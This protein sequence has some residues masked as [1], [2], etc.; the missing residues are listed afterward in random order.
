VE[1]W[2]LDG[3]LTGAWEA[4]RRPG[5]GDEGCG[6]RNSG[7]EHAQA[8]RVGNGAGDECGEEGRALCCFIGSEGKRNRAA[9]GGGINVGR[10]VWWGGETE[11]W[12]GSEEGGKCGAIF[13]RGGVIGAAAAR[14]GGA[15]GGRSGFRRK[16]AAR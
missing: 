5:D 1:R 14:A 9:G 12:V 16:K 4:V 7:A 3:L 8:R 10:P 6:R 13:G 11:G 2:E 15:D